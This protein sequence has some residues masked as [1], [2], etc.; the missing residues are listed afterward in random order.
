[1]FH[2]SLVEESQE[3]TSSKSV[4]RDMSKCIM[5]DTVGVDGVALRPL[6]AAGLS[7]ITF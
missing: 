1:M 4:P 2:L 6:I 7:T 3:V 5:A